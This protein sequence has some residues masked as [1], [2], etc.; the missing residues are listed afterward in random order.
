MED[1][2]LA[3]IMSRMAQS[4]E[5]DCS[6]DD[7]T[8]NTIQD[9]LNEVA[10]PDLPH[11]N[12]KKE[13]VSHAALSEAF[14]TGTA[15]AHKAAEDVHF[16]NNFIRGKIDRGL[17]A[18][19]VMSLYKVYDVLEHEL[20]QHAP[21]HFHTC[22]FPKELNRKEALKEDIDFW[23]GRA[24]MYTTA[25]TQDYINRIRQIA[26]ENPLLLL[27]H[28]YT[29]YLGDLSGGK[30]LARVARK[31]LNLSRDGDGLAFYDFPHIQ[32]PKLFKDHYRRSLDELKLDQD[33]ILQLVAEANVA[34]ILNMRIFEE[35]DVKANVP[36]AKVRSLESAMELATAKPSN[37]DAM[38]EC[39]FLKK[40]NAAK[41]NNVETKKRCPWPF[42]FA[43]DPITGL[44]EYQTWVFIALLVSWLWSRAQG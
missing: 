10:V 11:I 19:L 15:V 2:S 23:H 33:Q 3:A 13:N 28:A 16:V 38:D 18:D 17:Y 22:H 4:L 21:Q 6:S 5:E 30:I 44:K 12:S 39:P 42:I 27:S 9:Q 26:K 31:S 1:L 34:F 40:K 37:Q 29:R 20:D 36:G 25:A 35:L 43:H 8:E 32:S 7:E 41:S 14:K 24:P